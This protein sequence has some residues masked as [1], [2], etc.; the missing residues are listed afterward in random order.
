MAKRKATKKD[1][2]KARALMGRIANF[3][4]VIA[5]ARDQMQKD[6]NGLTELMEAIES[7]NE[8]VKMGLDCIEQGLDEI[9]QHV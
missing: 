7:A 1:V 2:A 5:E 6:L 8:D 9:S 4:D 3:K